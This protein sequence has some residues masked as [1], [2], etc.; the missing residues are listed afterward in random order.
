MQNIIDSLLDMA[1]VESGEIKPVP[2]VTNLYEFAESTF[3]KLQRD[4]PLPRPLKFQLINKLRSTDTV[5]LDPQHLSQ[6]LLNLFRNAVKFTNEGFITFS[7]ERKDNYYSISVSDTGIGISQEK[8]VYIFEPFRQAHE[9]ISRSKG[10]IGLGLAIARRL[11]ELWE[12]K[13]WVESSPGVGST[14]YINIPAKNE[15]SA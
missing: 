7:Y 11:V 13:I 10:G 8:I 5:I 3:N 9:G 14:F 6:A 15:Y 2:I 12:G 1:I 4:Y